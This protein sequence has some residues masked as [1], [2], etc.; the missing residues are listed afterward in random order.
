MAAKGGAAR[1]CELCGATMT[2]QEA[3]VARPYRYDLSGLDSVFLADIKVFECARCKVQLPVIP[4]V[5]ML[6]EAIAEDIISSNGLL[7]GKE[8][9]FLRKNAGMAAKAFAELI[10]VDVAHLSRVENGKTKHLGPAAD[11]LARSVALAACDGEGVRQLLL[12]V[13]QDRINQREAVFGL[14]K[15]H[16]EKLAA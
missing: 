15:N 16:W 6:H 3:T 14:K 10:R 4:R 12:K 8:V 1:K 7:S 13:G 2:E 11:K 9:R 5:A